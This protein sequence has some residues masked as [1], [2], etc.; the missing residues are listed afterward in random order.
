MSAFYT[1]VSKG[2]FD[3]DVGQA[4][5]ITSASVESPAATGKEKTDPGG[6]N[7]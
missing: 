7:G 6:G 3:T 5:L 4:A 2:R 1:R